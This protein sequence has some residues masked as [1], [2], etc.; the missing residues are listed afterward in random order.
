M[1]GF[2][3]SFPLE[4]NA[5]TN[6]RR[7]IILNPIL[8]PI[9]EVLKL[10]KTKIQKRYMDN[11][12]GLYINQ[13]IKIKINKIITNKTIIKI[14]FFFTL[15][16]TPHLC[17]LSILISITYFPL[18]DNASFDFIRNFLIHFIKNMA[19]YGFHPPPY[20]TFN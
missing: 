2:T 20:E 11:A 12:I 10:G 3:E 17:T 8:S 9:M 18:T 13:V 5:K 4:R 15:N 7:F 6:I 14:L 1:N 19:G 16:A